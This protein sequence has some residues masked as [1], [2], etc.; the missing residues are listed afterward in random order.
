MALMNCPRRPKFQ[1]QWGAE[2]PFYGE[3][4]PLLIRDSELEQP[5]THIWRS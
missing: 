2:V 1:R 5:F 4:K 3:T